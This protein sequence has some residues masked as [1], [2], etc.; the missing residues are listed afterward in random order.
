MFC[1]RLSG[2]G[3]VLRNAGTDDPPWLMIDLFARWRAPVLLVARTSLG[4][5]NHSL[6]SIEALRARSI[7]IAGLLFVGDAHPDNEAVIP[8]IAGVRSFGRLPH[9]ETLDAAHLAQAM[10]NHID[11]AALRAVMGMAQ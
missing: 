2:L 9:L 4:T 7:P 10:H 6:L 1:T 5:I 11:L 3:C 8:A